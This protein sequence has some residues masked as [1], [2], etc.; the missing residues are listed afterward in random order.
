MK[1]RNLEEVKREVK[2]LRD[3]LGMP[4]DAKIKDLVI[5]LRRW[6]INTS[7]S[8]EGHLKEGLPYPWVEIDKAD[9]ARVI[10]ILQ[11]WWQ[12]KDKNIPASVQ[13]RWVIKAF[14]NV[15]RI[16]PEDKKSR[17][18]EEMQEDAIAFGKFLQKLPDDYFEKSS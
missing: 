12:G 17:S 1:P 14:A 5:G 7:M 10:R 2:S 6:G 18:L 13:P 16:M 8:C 15:I 11:L 9:I 3:S 4:V